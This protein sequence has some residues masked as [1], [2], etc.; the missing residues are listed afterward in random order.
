M[1]NIKLSIIMPLFNV[2]KTVELALDSILMQHTD[3]EYE[4]IAV[5]DKSTDATLKIL[6][7]YAK[8]YKQIR[9]IK[10]T[11]NLGNAVSFYDAL[12]ASRGDY[13]CVLDG[14]DYY[15][16]KNKLQ[17]QV[18]FLDADKD[19]K[20]T[21]CTHKYLRI[22]EKYEIF[23]DKQI[24]SGEQDCDYLNFLQY[25]FYSHTST[26]MYRNIF[27]NNV[28]EVFKEPLY[29]GDNPRTFLHML[30]T[31]G[32]I[33]QLDFVGSVYLFNGK[34]IWSKMSSKD[35]VQR[36]LQMKQELCR[37]LL[38][39][40]ERDIFGQKLKYIEQNIKK[41]SNSNVSTPIMQFMPMEYFCEILYNLANK[42]AFKYKDFIFQQVYKSEFIDSF[43]E[44][45]GFIKMVQRGYRPGKSIKIDKTKVMIT[46]SAL[47]TTGGGVYYEIKDIIEMYHNFDVYLLLTDISSAKDLDKKVQQQLKQFDNLTCLY[48]K[49]TTNGKLDVLCNKIL[50]IK[51][52]K[53]YHYCGHNNIYLACLI[54]SMLSKN[55]CVFSFDHGFSLGLDNTNYEC[56]IT[57]RTMDYEL[58]SKN[59]GEKVI[60][61]PAWNKDRVKHNAY[62]PF[63]NHDTLITACA[64]AR[65][66]KLGMQKNAYIDV[67]LNVLKNTHGKH[68]HYGPI[69]QEELDSIYSKLK[70]L[71]LPE[72]SFINIPW[73]DNLSQSMYDNNVDIFIEPFPVVSYKITLD[74]LSAG[75]PVIAHKGHTRMGITDFI[76]PE[77]LEWKTEEDLLKT[78]SDINKRDLK[79]HSNLSRSYYEQN[80]SF[81]ILYKYFKAEKKFA[82]PKVCEKFYDNHLIDVSQIAGLINDSLE[83]KILTSPEQHHCIKKNKIRRFIE[84]LALQ[85]RYKIFFYAILLVVSTI[86]I[87]DLCIRSPARQKLLRKIQKWYR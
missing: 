36:N 52:S 44:T 39:D 10:H 81:K 85:Q 42:Y 82:L 83:Y 57:K 63:H 6:E 21:A 87:I 49:N 17:K 3:F 11:T 80:H 73:A 25:K 62:Q 47:N 72:D 61:I 53:I 41:L 20:Y 66:Y 76:Y 14:D 70:E 48:G 71:D 35:Q 5:D 50:S 84:K 34:G 74:V 79:K 2:E 27:R 77:H 4:I 8:T 56:Y 16:V 67:I 23:D 55:I 24:F 75:I 30:W 43:C 7:R 13:M 64:A 68:I 15:T 65:Y 31:K 22:N 40:V 1:S 38:S 12:C 86:P 58:L 69:P 60:F 9:V 37:N 33:K 46:I 18:D 32:K 78:L 26:Y 29:R 54:Q 45:I 19:C 28:P 51:P 59:Y